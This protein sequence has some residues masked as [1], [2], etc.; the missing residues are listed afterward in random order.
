MCCPICGE[1]EISK[2]FKLCDNLKILGENFPMSPSYVSVCGVC[3]LI[4]TDTSATQEDLLKYYKNGAV[5]PKY[6][7][8]FGKEATEEYYHHLLEVTKPYLHE[9]SKILDIAGAWGEF[10]SFM[11]KK[12]FS[13]FINL[14]PNETCV[15]SSKEKGIDTVLGD[16]T[17]MRAI[18]S[19]SIDFVFLNHTLEHILDVDATMKNINRVLK[20]DGHLFIEVPDIEGYVDEEAAPY[21]FLTYEHV[22]HMSMHDLENL[23]NK[24]GYEIIDSN[25]YYKRVSNYPSVYAIMHKGTKTETIYSDNSKISIL[26]YLEKSKDSLDKFINPLRKSGEELVLWGIGASTA[27]LLDSFEGCNVKSLI[28]RNPK[29][30]GLCFKIN[31]KILTVEDPNTVNTGT[32]VI[33][34]IPYHDSIKKQIREIGLTNKIVSLK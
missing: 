2:L 31:D 21:N 10:G 18:Y 8:M 1:R 3:G 20:K 14:D 27:I 19:D 7:D 6:L 9:D 24:Y 30:Q 29:R 25:H 11:K 12:G 4:F 17:D 34:S 33:L 22:L 13:H 32:I 15:E 16:S 28:D 26:N 23:A 5:A